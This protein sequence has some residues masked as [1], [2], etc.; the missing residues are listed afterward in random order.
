MNRST[1]TS[2]SGQSASSRAIDWTAVWPVIENSFVR[3]LYGYHPDAQKR[4]SANLTLINIAGGLREYAIGHAED[5]VTLWDQLRQDTQTIDLLMDC[6]ADMLLHTGYTV[7][8]LAESYSQAVHL[9]IP[10]GS[11]DGKELILDGTVAD[12]SFME[13]V[14]PQ[15]DFSQLLKTNPWV[16]YLLLLKRTGKLNLFRA[17][18]DT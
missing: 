5:L 18:S 2:Q 17:V 13:S 16:L 3:A 15:K 10:R 8:E 12:E 1:G 7:E 11:R 14:A 4:Q 6:T 9:S